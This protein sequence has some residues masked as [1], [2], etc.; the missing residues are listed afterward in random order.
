MAQS[1]KYPTSAEVMI[2][3]SMGSRPASGSVLTAQS[4]ERASNSVSPSLSATPRLT[5][6]LSKI[7]MKGC[8]RVLVQGRWQCRRT[9]GSPR[10]ADH[11]DSTHI[12][13]NNPQNRPKTSRTDSPEPSVDER[14]TEEGRKGGE[15]VHA[16]QTGGREP[17]RWRGSPPGKAEPPKSSL[18]KW[19][20]QTL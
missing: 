17:G 13:L 7:N 1:V 5:L 16:T 9:L 14:P 20:G 6:S 8:L 4:L 15:A 19:R 12:G 11:L 10:P 3:R 2:S 18:Q